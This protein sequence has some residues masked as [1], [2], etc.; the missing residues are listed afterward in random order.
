M[1][2]IKLT[3]GFVALVDDDDYEYLNQFKWCIKTWEKSR[4]QYAA[5]YKK[6]DGKYKVIPMHRMI[7]NTPIGMEV[8]HRDGNGLNNQKCNLRNCTH[9]DNM[10]NRKSSRT[11]TS[12]YLGVSFAKI[13]G[14]EYITAHCGK[15]NLGYFKTEELAAKAYKD[16]AELIYG[17]FTN[18]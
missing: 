6:I 14:Y 16:Y 2:E 15:I 17:E 13:R 18:K 12:K 7:M 4:T 5:R 8:D 11:G 10:R 9:S 3:K 1:K